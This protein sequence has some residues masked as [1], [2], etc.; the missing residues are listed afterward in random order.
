MRILGQEADRAR[1]RR[2]LEGDAAGGE[3]FEPGDFRAFV[4]RG[5]RFR[6]RGGVGGG[7]SRGS[8]EKGDEGE[9]AGAGHPV[10]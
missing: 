3:G 1:Q 9:S 8:G 10:V 5:R 2:I 6:R 7:A 4:R